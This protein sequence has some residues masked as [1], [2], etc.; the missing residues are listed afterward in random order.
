MYFGQFIENITRDYIHLRY[1]NVSLRD[2]LCELGLIMILVSN[3]FQIYKNEINLLMS[4][5]SLKKSKEKNESF[6]C[7]N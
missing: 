1:S 6:R 3:F 2:N 7:F 4:R 5:K